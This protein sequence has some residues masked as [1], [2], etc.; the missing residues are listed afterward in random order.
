[1]L[2]LVYQWFGR[3]S[4]RPITRDDFWFYFGDVITFHNN[5][6]LSSIDT[7]KRG[8]IP[9]TRGDLEYIAREID[10]FL[11]HCHP[12]KTQ[13]K[14]RNT[15]NKKRWTISSAD[16]LEWNFDSPVRPV[17]LSIHN[18]G[19]VTETIKPPSGILSGD[20][21]D[22]VLHA[23]G[24]TEQTRLHRVYSLYDFIHRYRN[25]GPL[26]A[27]SRDSQACIDPFFYLASYSYG[28]CGCTAYSVAT[29][30]AAAGISSRVWNIDFHTFPEFCI[31]NQW[32]IFDPDAKGWYLD[33][34]QRRVGV[35]E[36]VD[37]PEWIDAVTLNP[38][39]EKVKSELKAAFA[40]RKKH[41]LVATG[42]EL[43]QRY[44]EMPRLDWR[45]VLLPGET[46]TW[47]YHKHPGW[48]CV[49]P[50][51]KALSP[52]SHL[53]LMRSHVVFSRE[54][55]K[56]DDKG[57]RRLD[58]PR[59]F[60]YPLLNGTVTLQGDGVNSSTCRL[61]VASSKG[62]QWNV[63]PLREQND[64]VTY[65]LGRC[66]YQANPGD[67]FHVHLE[68]KEHVV[69]ET[70]SLECS[71][72]TSPYMLPYCMRGD[73]I[74]SFGARVRNLEV[75]LEYEHSENPLP[76]SF[77]AVYPENGAGLT[78]GDLNEIRWNIENGAIPDGCRFEFI[79]SR[80]GDILPVVPQW[81]AFVTEMKYPVTPEDMNFL[82]A[83]SYQWRIRIIDE[84]NHPITQW[85][86]FDFV[87]R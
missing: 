54:A 69:V 51:F 66:F 76:T 81:S 59:A 26:P 39:Y 63:S 73:N 29:L 20:D 79:L 85:H 49:G 10:L 44:Y 21:L 35:K 34:D 86:G 4:I 87:L 18:A 84:W 5:R 31:D 42:E 45:L 46:L 25:H 13:D 60:P 55:W 1:M 53:S 58:V 40:Q 77:T 52:P 11:H 47:E 15:K 43:L 9:A 36:L 30:A 32:V 27:A 24:I 82:S 28:L 72:Q 33:P 16:A 7:L 56:P 2:R 14:N 61:R 68:S 12:V 23:A 64:T 17:T 70:T 74:L 80:K 37:H 6:R 57:R 67:A 19:N 8:K 50:V 62:R 83:G 38:L 22:N 78:A 75:E 65:T 71:L 41:T 48:Q 3:L